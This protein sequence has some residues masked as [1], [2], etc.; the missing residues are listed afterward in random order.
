[1]FMETGG[2]MTGSGYRIDLEKAQLDPSSVFSSSNDYDVE[3]SPPIKQK[4]I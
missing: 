1:M 2:C 3:H 4:G